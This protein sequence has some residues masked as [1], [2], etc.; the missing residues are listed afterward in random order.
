MDDDRIE[1]RPE[2]VYVDGATPAQIAQLL[3]TLESDGTISAD[4]ESLSRSAQASARSL[5]E[6]LASHTESATT[7]A[8]PR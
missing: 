3:A 4:R 1:F 8:P 7:P 6:K 5:A 2:D